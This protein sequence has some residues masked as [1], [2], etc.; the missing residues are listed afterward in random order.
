MDQPTTRRLLL[1]PWSE[2]DRAHFA[3]LARDPRVV[4]YIGDG[5]TWSPERIDDVFERQVRHWDEHGFGWRAALLRETGEWVGFVGLNHV[6]PEAIE[7]TGDEVEI[8]WWINPDV[9]GR[10]IAT[11]AALTLRDEGFDR[12]GLDRI[13]GRY[14]PDNVASGRIMARLGMTVER[15][16]VGRH[17]ERI[18]IYALE[19]DEWLRRAE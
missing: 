13:I 5:S 17:G 2:Q 8:G 14:Q 1:R 15:D 3:A 6:G 12:V 18:R 4:R 9:W 11:E 10:G 16:A 19:R 7:I